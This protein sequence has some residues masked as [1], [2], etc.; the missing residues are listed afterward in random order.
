MDFE[1]LLRR[2]KIIFSFCGITPFEAPTQSAQKWK[3]TFAQLFPAIFYSLL[4]IVLI[5]IATWYRNQ[6][7]LIFSRS[8]FEIVSISIAYTRLFIE[9]LLQMVFIGQA[10]IFRERMKKLCRDYDYI[11][12]YMKSRMEHNIDFNVLQRRFYQLIIT[13]FLPH[14]TTFVLRRAL[15]DNRFLFVMF[16]NVF[17]IFYFLASVLQIYI[18]VHVELLR[19]FVMQMT[20]WLREQVS[21]LSKSSLCARKDLRT[22]QMNGYNKILQLKFLHFKLWKLSLDFNRIFGWSLAALI[23]RNSTEIAYGIYWIYLY[24]IKGARLRLILRKLT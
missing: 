20:N 15:V 1:T 3:K 12:N 14:L 21:E 13:V 19:F 9:L 24:S 22:Q 10:F 6:F 7:T 5:A 17:T 18:I 4:V 23:L 16:L 11:Q 2:F 8:P